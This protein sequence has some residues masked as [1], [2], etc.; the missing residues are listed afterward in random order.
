MNRFL[1]SL[2]GKKD[3]ER[4]E[5]TPPTTRQSDGP[6]GDSSTGASTPNSGIPTGPD[7]H[8]RN[9]HEART[10]HQPPTS[11]AQ[12]GTKSSHAQPTDP[13]RG[14][15]RQSRQVGNPTPQ[16][17]IPSRNQGAQTP[18][19]AAAKGSAQDKQNNSAQKK[20]GAKPHQQVKPATPKKPQKPQQ[21]AA[22]TKEFP[23]SPSGTSRASGTSGTSRTSTSAG[24]K[25]SSRS[26]NSAGTPRPSDANRS[27]GTGSSKPSDDAKNSAQGTTEFPAQQSWPA[28]RPEQRKPEQRK[29]E[30]G[31]AEQRKTEPRKPEQR[32]PEQH[33]SGQQQPGQRQQEQRPPEQRKSAPHQPEQQASGSGRPQ[34]EQR[35]P[36]HKPASAQEQESGIP[37]GEK[38]AA[39]GAASQPQRLPA[40]QTAREHQP[41][42]VQAGKQSSPHDTQDAN[43]SKYP[44]QNQQNDSEVLAVPPE[45]KNVRKKR[46]ARL[47]Q[48]KG[49]DGLRGLAVIAVVLYHFFGDALPGGYLGVDMFFVLSGFLI[50]SL[51]VREYRT[52]GTISLKDFWVRRFRRILPAAVAVLV[53]CTAIVAWIGGDLAVGLRQQFFGTLFFVN[54]WTQIATS[55]SYFADNEVQ[56][57]A[58]YWS[59]AVEE[60]F[61]LI[62]PLLILVIFRASSRQPRRL[63]VVVASVLGLASFAAMWFIFTPGEDPTR[64]Y[65]G[66][67]THAFGLLTGAVLSLLMTSTKSDPNADS[68]ATS[69]KV[70]T[71]AAGIIGFLALIGYVAQLFLMPDDAEFTYR[72]GLFLTSILGALMVWGV[73]HEYGPMTPLFRTKVMR[74]FGQR[75]FS[76]Y[77]WHWP[78]IMILEALFHGNQNS[79]NTWILGTV[80]VPI[81][82]IL[83]EI[84]YQFIENPFRRGG[85][86]KTWK[87]YW[88]A[89]PS[90]SEL[91][92][93]FGKAMWPV[94]PFLVVASLVGVVYGVVNSNDKTELE[95]QLDQLQQQNQNNNPVP[96]EAAAPSTPPAEDKE[97]DAKKED[98]TKTRPMP[99]GTNITAIGDSVMLAASDAL[100]QRFPGI[101]IDAEESRHYAS[102]IQILQQMKNA[103]TLRD[104][105]FLGFGTNGAAQPNQI[106]Q[107]MDI[108]GEDHTVVMV[109]PYGDREWMAQSQKDVIDAAKE[110]DNAYIADWCG[111]AKNNPEMLYSDGVHP[112]PEGASGYSDAFYNALKQYSKYDKSVSSQCQA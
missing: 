83:S 78:V 77:L 69:G 8:A 80:A 108:I 51:L 107:A 98:D 74:W 58:H 89:R 21:P 109:V 24:S 43:K 37:A 26:N 15:A 14:F 50:T 57:F 92:D 19:S 49:L 63:P 16:D 25:N 18:K 99:Q 106:S 64:V 86:K 20:T 2:L 35:K 81:S 44:L 91:K 95:Q 39:M 61:Y 27:T 13:T 28:Q 46:H 68:W 32:K 38:A 59:L 17:K 102:G 52:S 62:W 96:P 12:D 82:L 4:N 93:G 10:E 5:A 73:I 105:V 85:Y 31:K 65:Y 101:Y 6:T 30:Q 48:V 55:Q 54:N 7:P 66:T 40:E 53:F 112:L 67:D 84:S 47:R 33:T 1:R 111:Y 103:G 90:F 42:A 88:A 72:G 34:A 87:N 9:N 60:Q 11:N 36:A 41:A 23:A 94:V 22:E 79:E 75:S 97:D 71:R 56:V 3:S 29:P 76:L 110:Y 70:E 104:T 100:S 45:D